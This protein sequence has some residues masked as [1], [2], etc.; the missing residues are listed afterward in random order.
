[1]EKLGYSVEQAADAVG[2]GRTEMYAR[3]ATG[4]IESVKVGRRRIVP[5]DALREWLDQLRATAKAVG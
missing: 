4:E 2:I 5:A 3:L 1:M